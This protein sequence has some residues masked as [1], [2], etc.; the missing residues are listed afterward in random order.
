VPEVVIDR[1]QSI[2]CG[3]P[4]P[5]LGGQRIATPCPALLPSRI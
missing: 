2:G 5:H 1:P 4:P 3:L